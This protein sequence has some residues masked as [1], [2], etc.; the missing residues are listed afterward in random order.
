MTVH[1]L[2]M[3]LGVFV[4]PVL[5]LSAAHRFRRRS[6]HV[7]ALFWGALNGHLAALVVGTWAALT[8]AEAWAPNDMVR[9]AL[10][11]WSFLLLPLIGGVIASA[12]SRRNVKGSVGEKVG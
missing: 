4:V 11:L 6:P 5:L 1:V 12:R 2:A 8:P 3:L 9:G 10:G 7:R